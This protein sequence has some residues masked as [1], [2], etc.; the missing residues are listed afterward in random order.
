M[1]D[2]RHRLEALRGE[3]KK[4][5][6]E[7]NLSGEQL[8][9]FV[10]KTIQAV[11][12]GGTE[13]GIRQTINLINELGDSLAS[14][15]QKSGEFDQIRQKLIEFA[16]TAE[17]LRG[18]SAQA[19]FGGLRGLPQEQRAAAIT[20]V[21]RVPAGAS[22][23]RIR[24]EDEINRIL[25]EQISV[26]GARRTVE[27]IANIALRQRITNVREDLSLS[28]QLVKSAERRVQAQ[29]QGQR[30]TVVG[31]G[32]GQVVGQDPE[33]LSQFEAESNV[34]LQQ[35]IG[36]RQEE[37]RIVND[38]LMG[39]AQF[40]DIQRQLSINARESI[41]AFTQRVEL[42][43]RLNRGARVE[44]DLRKDSERLL[45]QLQQQ[46]PGFDPD[47]PLSRTGGRRIGSVLARQEDIGIPGGAEGVQNFT[48]ALRAAG[49]EGA[50]LTG[51]TEDIATGVR[52]FGLEQQ[53]AN[54]VVRRGSI[55]VNRLGRVLQTGSR[56]YR[57]FTE[58]IVRNVAKVAEWTIAI[59]ITFAPL[60]I[61][62]D[63]M[64]RAIS[65]QD[66]LAEVTV[67][68][69]AATIDT[70]KI[71]QAAGRIAQETGTEVA[72]VIQSFAQAFAATGG[73][74]TQ[75]IRTA[76]ATT[77]LKDSQVLAKLAGI[78][79]AQALD[80]LVGVLRQ[81]NRGFDEGEA[82]LDRFV[83]VARNANVSINTLASVFAIVGT[84]AEDAGISFEQLNAL[85]ATLAEAT[86]LSADETGNA[87]RGFVSGFQSARA[88]EV[89]ARFGIAIRD[90]SGNVRDFTDLLREL[91]RLQQEE[92]LDDTAIREITNAIGG[93]FRRGAQFATLLENFARTQ[94]LVT[95]QQNAQGEAA[96]ALEA[97]LDTL[98]T[99]TVQLG[100]SMTQLASALGE[101]GGVLSVLT[102]LANVLTT[103]VEALAGVARTGGP[104]LTALLAF[105]TVRSA[106]GRFEFLQG[107]AGAAIPIAGRFGAV[108]RA[109][110]PFARLQGGGVGQ[111]SLGSLFGAANLAGGQRLGRIAGLG[112]LTR[113]V[114]G[115]AGIL[116]AGV[117][118]ITA[119]AAI[120]RG[121]PEEAAGAL[122]GA[123]IGGLIGSATIIGTPIGVAIGSVLGQVFVDTVT[124]PGASEL[125]AFFA[126]LG[127][128]RARERAKA[129]GEDPDETEAERRSRIRE[130]FDKALTFGDQF[131]TT[132]NAFS[133]IVTRQEEVRDVPF[134]QVRAVLQAERLS[135]LDNEE[136]NRAAQEFLDVIIKGQIEA[137]QPIGATMSEAF[138][139]ELR[140]E[141]R[142]I[143]QA[144]AQANI[145]E[146]LTAV[147]RGE[148]GAT[149]FAE[150]R[151][152]A[153]GF[154][155]QL[156]AL[157]TTLKLAGEEVDTL[158]FGQ[159]L[160][161]L[162]D[163]QRLFLVQLAKEAQSAADAVAAGTT[164]VTER[165]KAFDALIG[166]ADPAILAA[167]IGQIDI[168]S[169][170]GL[171][172]VTEEESNQIIKKALELQLLFFEQFTDDPEKLTEL[173]ARVAEQLIS[174]T[175]GG[176]EQF[177]GKA[178]VGRRFIT[179]A[180][181]QLGLDPAD[182]PSRNLRDLRD[183]L[184]LAD[185]PALRDRMTQVRD[186]IEANF[187]AFFDTL[188]LTEEQNL[189][190][191]DGFE[192]VIGNGTLFNLALQDLIELNEQQL[193]GIFNIPEGV[194][195]IIPFT[196]ALGFVVGGGGGGGGG[197]TGDFAPFTD[198]V[199]FSGAQFADDIAHSLSLVQGVQPVID[200]TT[201]DPNTG[202][203]LQPAAAAAI[204]AAPS[205]E[206][207]R[208]L[209][210]SRNLLTE[211]P[212]LRGLGE[213]QIRQIFAEQQQQAQI[214]G[215]V[216][217]RRAP[218]MEE[219][220]PLFR[221]NLGAL[222]GLFDS[223][224]TGFSE[225]FGIGVEEPSLGAGP[226]LLGALAGVLPDSIP[227]SADFDITLQN[228]IHIDGRQ[229]AENLQNIQFSEF[230]N[231][232]RREGAVG[233]EVSV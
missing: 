101:E 198:A 9:D 65:T 184:S 196:G 116:G 161:Q 66:A 99:S 106:F 150:A 216:G 21:R 153:P 96:A 122:V 87:I 35:R 127:A 100:N 135:L 147:Q 154:P 6:V 181:E 199:P 119:G 141:I 113:G 137:G 208:F 129:R 165:E 110:L 2:I 36:L 130:D 8:E 56:R 194:S 98:S 142:P 190:L 45:V 82:V 139:D 40:E 41:N 229:I 57:G 146:T 228:L 93:G 68:V 223:I 26:I 108:G 89:L 32:A 203:P 74:E 232:T 53:L 118:A 205:V 91:A 95:V 156:L 5:R 12:V 175:E 33:R 54:G 225:L 187:P 191:S 55:A 61:L 30:A 60:R 204:D 48:N 105:A 58:S 217:E 11:S 85:A 73:L 77:L 221:G 214:L 173:Q 39:F 178:Q 131:V 164:D 1:P 51:V 136:A 112:R 151:E 78:E 81:T 148:A 16:A 97:R 72:G 215:I 10:V 70:A 62:S 76:A 18:T 166:F 128:E 211:N 158:E 50:Q 201:T 210:F 88:E 23:E 133:A 149:E 231:A 114:I 212:E 170:L 115:R 171:G 103:V 4:L 180:Q 188:D 207:Q 34:V 157:I 209:S 107:I 162:D 43:N 90:A 19:I 52:R 222:A 121:E 202:L 160:I 182:N 28:E 7:L 134:V 186:S 13:R 192:Q 230:A 219:M 67:A 64:E 179:Q 111:P 25:T 132:I 163:Q 104:A 226:E 197:A 75:A 125:E 59:A 3:L 174:I 27:L 86:K 167:Q 29:A 145:E 94:Q 109:A 138:A 123:V 124:G 49:L 24:Q 15:G 92:V 143:G 195:A 169:I 79:Q 144:I 47:T 37:Q 233:Y 189:I 120:A 38:F 152:I 193:E 159:A 83:V 206:E 218:V 22:Q 44:L 224:I 63:L 46:R 213:E 185:L 14:A 71:L 42:Q 200:L 183:E 17:R 126:D 69:G 84:A 176:V 117:T 102:L 20:G 168:L 220:E 172:D 31:R 155:E 227:I 80:T 140:G 177:L